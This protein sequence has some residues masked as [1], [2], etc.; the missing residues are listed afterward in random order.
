MLQIKNSLGKK[1]AKPNAN[2][3]YKMGELIHFFFFCYTNIDSS[4]YSRQVNCPSPWR[5]GT[6]WSRQNL[7]S[8]LTTKWKKINYVRMSTIL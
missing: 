3:V 1:C 4:V 7:G 8:E 5:P 2:K 6:R